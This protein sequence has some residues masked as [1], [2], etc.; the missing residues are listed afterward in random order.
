MLLDLFPGAL[1][2]D[3][4][5]GWNA[6]AERVEATERL[7]YEDLV[8]EESRAATP[9]PALVA[10]R[11]AEEA[12]ARGVRS[13]A[14]E[15]ALDQL[16]ARLSLVARHAPGIGATPPD[17]AA[18]RAALTA[19]CLG[20]RS[21]AEL[22]LADLPGALLDLQPGPVRAALAR[23]AP[24]KV[25]LPGGRSV[26]VHYEADRPPWIESRLQD[27]FSMARGPAVANGAEPLT[28][29]LLAPNHRAVQ[30][31]SDL[32]GFWERHYPAIRKELSRRYPRHSWPEDPRTAPPPAP[33]PPRQRGR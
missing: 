7:L 16:V 6:Q 32:S 25:T 15:G 12:L 23:L 22:R 3:T 26:R 10:A 14:E 17:E 8:L 19:S 1:H 30:V 24:E 33:L 9:D 2:Y 11:L 27:F 20:R 5:V 21:F 13:F 29:H 4:A 31:T 28:L 18:L